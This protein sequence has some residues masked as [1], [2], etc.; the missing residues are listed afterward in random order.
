MAN[1]KFVK[2]A[3][4]AVLGASVLTTA[5]VVPGADASAKT[6]YKVNKNGTLVNA[7]TNKAV[8]GY[9]TY[10]GK[11]YKNGK[12]FTGKT[13]SGVYYV[14]GKKFTGKTKYGYYYVNGKR[15]T[16][17]TKYGY[18]YVN[19]KRFNGKTKY[20][21][22]YVDG[23]RYTGTTKYGYTYYNGKR[24]EGEYKAK[25]YTNGKLVTGLYKEKLYNKGVL[26]TG[27]DLYKDK[28]YK[29]GVLN[30]GYALYNE[31]LYKDAAKNEGFVADPLKDGK[32]YND[33]K[34]ANGTFDVDGVE[35][36]YED[37][38]EVGAKVKSVEAI[39]AKQ[40]VVTFNK[41]VDVTSAETE[42]NYDF[43]KIVGSAIGAVPADATVQSDGKSVLLTLTTP[44][45]VETTFT[46]T[47]SGVKVKNTNDTFT[48]FAKSVSYKDEVKADVTDV[49]SLTNGS[50]ATSLKITFS[51]PVA[52]ATVKVDGSA[53]S[54]VIAADGLSATVSGLSLDATKEHSLEV[55]NLTDFANN[56]T[57]LVSKT[58][59]VTKDITNPN[60]S[61]SSLNDNQLLLTFDK[62]MNASTINTTNVKVKDELLNDLV[63]GGLTADPKDTTGTKFIADLPA[64]L[65]TSKD[66][67]NLTVLL[68]DAVTDSLGNKL[69][70]QFKNVTIS[71]DTA[72][73]TVSKVTFTKNATTGNVD[74]VVLEFNEGLAASAGGYDT[75]G[76]KVINPNGVDVTAGFFAANSTAVAKG[77]T[78]V[79]IPVSATVSSGKYTLYLP[80]GLVQDVAQT[81]INSSASTKV[82]DFGTA[83]TSEFK[84]AQ[85]A[86]GGTQSN[87][88]NTITVNYGTAVKGG[89]QTGSA[90]DV[91]NYTLNGAPLPDGTLITLNAGLD[92]ATI[93]LKDETVSKTDTAAVLRI[94][95]V[96]NTA[97]TVITPFVGTANVTDSKAPV[98]NSTLLNTNGTFTV[99]FDE[100]LAT[101]AVKGD[102]DVVVNGQTLPAASFAV[103]PGV[104]ADAG[105]YVFTVNGLVSDNGTAGDTTDDF[106]YIDVD[107]VA[108]YLA[109]GNDIKVTGAAATAGAVDLNSSAISSVKVST[110][111]AGLTGADTAGNTLKVST[112]KTV[113]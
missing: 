97:G 49:T 3:T 108:G 36:A 89:A 107:G 37:G 29:D 64:G 8:K 63:L 58:F 90:T 40:I 72:A 65:Y 56:V 51:E 105:K 95:G 31:D 52:A 88:D 48:S 43:S 28:L 25:V 113:K 46:T 39:N 1:F 92:T 53:K 11:L 22:L 66:S 62:K 4:A 16:G 98:L 91:N 6:T 100:T 45:T 18:Y 83:S 60:I 9:K 34:L 41:S 79:E 81:A 112:S 75:T 13:S 14:K 67:R 24:V 71:K 42:S 104:G 109:S 33:T 103:D 87:T 68:N 50:A 111:A 15:F 93:T 10:K 84:I 44:F 27:L 32:A 12:K 19:G 47:V 106:L 20:G 74:K 69:P 30:V 70:T 21:N 35:K 77:D 54:L 101:S 26:E 96:Q 7:K 86:I 82:V 59:N 80:T 17:T 78:K 110:K 23:K 61:V 2:S 55:L 85:A 99:G 76:I 57:S 102:F 38:V 73:P 5:V 94:T